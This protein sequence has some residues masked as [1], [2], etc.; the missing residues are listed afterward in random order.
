MN[1]VG[2]VMLRVVDAL[3]SAGIPYMVVGSFSTNLHG[4]PRSTEDVDIV[5]ELNQS[6]APEFDRLLGDE[7]EAEKQISFESNTGT[8]RQE[9]HVRGTEFTVE[10]FRLSND[11]FDQERFRRR[12]F[13]ENNGRRIS[14]ATPEDAI[15]MKLRWARVKD[16]EDVLAVM[17]VQRDNLDWKYIELWCDRLGKLQLLNELRSRLAKV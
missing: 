2:D 13:Y 15:V 16:K 5:I 9:F 11:A 8:Q 10:L 17:A 14:F 7:F 12:R 4:I 3:E 6:L 1:T